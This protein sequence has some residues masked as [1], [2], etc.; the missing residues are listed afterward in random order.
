M[1]INTGQ[2]PTQFPSQ[3]VSDEVKMSREYGLSVSRAIEQE[4][5]NRDNGPGMY[6]QTRDEFHRLRLYARGE[7][8]IRK[9]KDEFAVNG[10]LSYLNLDWKPVPI[11]PKFVDIVVNGMQ[12]RLFDIKAFAQDPISTGKRT[13]FVN[14]IQRDINAQEMLKQI[15]TQLGVNARN[16]PEEDLPANSEELELYMQLGYKQGIEIAEEQAINNVFLTNKF[17]ELKKRFDYD[18]TVLG[19]G[20]VKNTFNNTDGIKLDYVDP[21][22]LIW[23][24]TED[25]NFENCY[26]FGEVKRISL[27]ELKKEFPAL[28]DEEIYEL[29][30]KGSNWVDMY[31][32]NWQANSSGGDIDNNN[33]LTVLYFNWKT[34][35]NN[36]YKIKETSTGASRAIAKSDSFNPPQDKRTRFERVAQ[37]RE[38]VYEGVF[39]LGTDTMLK[40]KKA[41]NMIRPSSNTNKV[42]MNYIVS[43]PRIYKGKITSLVS[44][45][46]PYADLVQLTHL[47]LQQAIQ[48]MTPSGVFIDADG[49]AEVD[50]G[51][52]TSYNAQEAL[53][54]YFSTGSIIGRSLTVEGDPNPGRVPIQELP[55]SQGGQ[56]QVL[57]GAYN[58]YIQ[59]MRDVT[60]LNEARDGSDPD[61]NALVGVQKLAAANSNTATRHILS[62]SMYIT[63]ALAEAICLRFKDVLEFHPT[64]EAF[65]G[66]LGQF[67]VGSLEEMKNLHLHDFGIFLELMPDEEEKS[68]LEANIQ[69]ALSRDSI[70]LE[71]AID[72]R[73]VKNLKLAN[74]LLKIRRVRKQQMDQEQAQAASVA[75]AEAQGAAQ[76]Q[77][78]EAKAQAEQIKTASKIQY[79]QAD[80][81]FEIKKLEVEAQTK[82]EL[83]Q[84]EY[85]LN[86]KL[87]EL[88][89]RAQKELVEK[90]S[91]TQE[92][93]AA[94]KTST[95]SLS[96]P[97][98]SGKPAKS[99]ESKGNDVLGG[100]DL[101][102][103]SP[104]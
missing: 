75:Q 15:E 69:V 68:L 2:L 70:N 14:D 102:R 83:M 43:A 23:S 100:I 7:Q 41:T 89:L 34:W 76:V 8:S 28:P 58:Q 103:F 61:P 80:I 6:F 38:V 26:Y 88:E 22:N 32:N 54:M 55:G 53:N 3:A 67:S 20:A 29:T 25:P 40:W 59:M 86:V 85:E 74:Q 93:V 49:L 36:V 16:V 19:I 98:S 56:I 4:W 84:F 33:T 52:G 46:T 104:K 5:F 27:N 1:A 78:E 71:D 77:I 57:V 101:S 45:M 10:D 17:P 60:G 66:A 79:R 24:Y 62:S 50:L 11:I 42:L 97:P 13:K 73:E 47:K 65:I 12:D 35:E 64:K 21:A 96:G 9:Y 99:F 87:K 18:L 95:A 51:N 37:A 48:R 91:Q 31:N 94:M 30:K 63:L 44:K 82:R 92:T 72:I 81:E 39:V 90:Q